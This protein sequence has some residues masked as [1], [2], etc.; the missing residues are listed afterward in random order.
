MSPEKKLF[1][2]MKTA[3]KI[4]AVAIVGLHAMKA[5]PK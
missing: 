4:C 1:N 5:W 2:P 3:D